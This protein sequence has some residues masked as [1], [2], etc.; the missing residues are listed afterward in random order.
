M[1]RHTIRNKALEVFLKSISRPRGPDALK[2][3]VDHLEVNIRIS[4]LQSTE[5]EID[6]LLLNALSKS[7]MESKPQN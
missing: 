2:G 6:A 7:G 3:F 4:A 1:V 5:H